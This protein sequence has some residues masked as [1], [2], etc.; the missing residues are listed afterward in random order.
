MNTKQQPTI[1]T[2]DP[3]TL[4]KLRAF[5]HGYMQCN[6]DLGMDDVPSWDAE[7][8]YLGYGLR[9]DKNSEGTVVYATW[10]D[11]NGTHTAHVESL[12][13]LDYFEDPSPMSMGWVDGRGQP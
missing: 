13:D 11:L 8:E 3:T 10:Q 7:T 5:V 12:P 9:F 4:D 2:L 1:A 6:S